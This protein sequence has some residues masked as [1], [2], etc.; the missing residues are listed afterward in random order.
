M[1][2]VLTASVHVW[3]PVNMN[4]LAPKIGV[5]QMGPKK[6]NYDFLENSSNDSAFMETVIKN[7][8]AQMVSSGK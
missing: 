8:A 1:Q 7:K 5:L 2:M 4:I 6:Q 3:C